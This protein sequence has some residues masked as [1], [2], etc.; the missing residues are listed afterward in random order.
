MCVGWLAG[1]IV[2]WSMLIAVFGT[3]E[4]WKN[5]WHFAEELFA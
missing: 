1:C 3:L 5:V 2:R 4:R